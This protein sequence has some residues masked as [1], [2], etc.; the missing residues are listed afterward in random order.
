MNLKLTGFIVVLCLALGA[1]AYLSEESNA[2]EV[3]YKIGDRGPAGGWIFYDKGDNTEGWRYLEAAPEDQS[4]AAWGCIGTSI[5]NA[6]NTAVG[7][8]EKNTIAIIEG[9]GQN[10]IA[11]KNVNKY[12]GGGKADW[13]LPSKDELDLMYKKLHRSRIG[14]FDNRRSY[15][16][17]SEE[18]ERLAWTQRFMDGRQGASDK[19]AFSIRAI[20]AF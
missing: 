12:R 6:R 4:G 20:R 3:T 17:S 19:F 13:F 10:N 1:G 9:C 2:Q 15:L 16:S 11:A 8:G 7:T 5:P 14:N 18:N